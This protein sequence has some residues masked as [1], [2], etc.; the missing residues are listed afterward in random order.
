MTKHAVLA[1]LWLYAGWTLGSFLAMVLGLDTLLGP[2][3][4]AIALALFVVTVRSFR[5][6]P[7]DPS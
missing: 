6:T 3:T 7:T 5:R 1:F 2:A 4:G